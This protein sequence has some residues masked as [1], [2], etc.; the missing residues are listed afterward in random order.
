MKSFFNPWSAVVMYVP[1]SGAASAGFRTGYALT[2][3]ISP[4]GLHLLVAVYWHLR[5]D[6]CLGD[7][8]QKRQS[9]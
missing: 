7:F 1:V 2:P 4:Q 8:Q 6:Y 5:A 9:K 3:H